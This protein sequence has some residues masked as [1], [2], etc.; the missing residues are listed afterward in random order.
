MSL[1][2]GCLCGA[3]FMGLLFVPSDGVTLTKG[4]PHVYQSSPTSNRHFCASCGS[5]L[6]FERHTRAETALM[7]GSLDEPNTFKPELY[8]CMES[9][10]TWLD[11]RDGAP[12]YAQ[13]PE[14]MTPLVDYD[15]VTG[16]ISG[17]TSQKS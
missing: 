11:I 5:P 8:V 10:M 1:T 13:K 14:G 2:G 3:P 6:F 9:A 17:A 7:V 12:R 16:R 4:R 15:P